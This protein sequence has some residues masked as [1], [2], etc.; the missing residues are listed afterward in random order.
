MLALL[1]QVRQ[2]AGGIML[3]E[4]YIKCA[5]FKCINSMLDRLFTLLFIG[6]VTET[7]TVNIHYSAA[8]LS[9]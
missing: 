1:G 5:A 4:R 2:V 3:S 7:V 8:R 6:T 9:R